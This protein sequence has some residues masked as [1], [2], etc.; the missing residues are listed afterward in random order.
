MFF[1]SIMVGKS[2]RPALLRAVLKPGVK[3]GPNTRKEGN[4]IFS[5]GKGMDGIGAMS[6]NV[7]MVS[8]SMPNMKVYL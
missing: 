4:L 1:H 8:L 6:M 5:E 2:T 3:P 7:I